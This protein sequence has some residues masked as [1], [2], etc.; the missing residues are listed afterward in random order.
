MTKIGLIGLEIILLTF[1]MAIVV[2]AIQYCE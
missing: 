1:A 2:I